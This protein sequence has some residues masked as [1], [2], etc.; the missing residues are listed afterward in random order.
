MRRPRSAALSMPAASSKLSS[1]DSA[2]KTFSVCGT[3]ARPLRTNM[4]A[5]SPVIS[6]SS[7]YTAPDWIGA[8]PAIALINVDLPAPLGPRT[9]TI[10]PAAT[11]RQAPLTIDAPGSYPAKSFLTVKTEFTPGYR[12][13]RLR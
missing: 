4:C 5:G 13:G 2:A 6:I 9:A 8:I 12:R 11:L 10:S 1:T 3:K 7:R